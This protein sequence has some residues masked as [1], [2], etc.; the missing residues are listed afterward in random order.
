MLVAS[1]PLLLH[2]TGAKFA[3]AD[4]QAAYHAA[5]VADRLRVARSSLTEE[6]IARWIAQTK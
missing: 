3:T 2:N 4:L 1:H 6:E 5:G